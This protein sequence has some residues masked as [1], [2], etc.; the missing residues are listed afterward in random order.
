MKKAIEKLEMELSKLI[1]E[2]E[3]YDNPDTEIY[4]DYE[5][6]IW[7]IKEALEYIIPEHEK[8]EKQKEINAKELDKEIENDQGFQELLKHI[9]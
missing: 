6:A 5:E 2:S 4:W 7:D 3:K 1:K 8:R 9:K